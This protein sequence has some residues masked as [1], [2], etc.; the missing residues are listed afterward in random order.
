M[1][2]YEPLTST[3]FTEE[4]SSVLR[5]QDQMELGALNQSKDYIKNAIANIL[6]KSH[7]NYVL[8]KDDTVLSIFGVRNIED[9]IGMPWFLSAE[10]P[11]SVNCQFLKL[12]K[13]IV[14]R[15]QEKYDILYNYTLYDNMV[16]HKWLKYLGFQII[17][18]NVIK[19]CDGRKLVRFEWR[20]EWENY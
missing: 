11:K 20:R 9:G 13:K 7:Y 1:L 10:I 4:W 18:D 19:K 6:Q 17:Y 8:Y 16:S 12:S 2:Y 14:G 5:L 3:D 15:F